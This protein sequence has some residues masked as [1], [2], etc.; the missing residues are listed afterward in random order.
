MMKQQRYE[1]ALRQI[2]A[3]DFER[4]ARGRTDFYS[5]P[6]RFVSAWLI[7]FKVL[8]PEWAGIAAPSQPEKDL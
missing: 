7:A 8:E 2:L 4:D 1:Q 3:L 5:G 6:S